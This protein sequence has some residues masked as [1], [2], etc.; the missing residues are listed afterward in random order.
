VVLEE[1]PYSLRAE[2]RFVG[3]LSEEDKEE[4]PTLEEAEQHLPRLARDEQQ[5]I[6]FIASHTLRIHHETD[7]K[8]R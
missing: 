2:K 1:L 7:Y 5:Q 6:I 4:F 8:A 3:F